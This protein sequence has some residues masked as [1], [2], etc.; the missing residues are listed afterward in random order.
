[1]IQR[2]QTVYLF[3]ITILSV[4]LLFNPVAGLINSAESV[5]YILN[6]KG[7][8]LINQEAEVVLASIWS[9]NAIAI[10]IPILSFLT[11]F[12]FNKRIL[13]LRLSFI[14]IVLMAGYYGVL[15]IYIW[16]YGKELN[17][18]WYLKS[19]ASFHLVNIILCFLAIRSIG[20]DEA[21]VKSLNRLR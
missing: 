4:V 20:K 10:I 2:I 5:N 8:V 1:M 17:A 18:D 21:L 9:L 14:N 12:L 7:L 15:F 16:Q 19:I 13:Q 3:I 11:I 6:F